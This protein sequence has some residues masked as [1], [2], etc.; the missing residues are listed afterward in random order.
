MAA[1]SAP[2]A[3]GLRGTSVRPARPDGSTIRS[4]ACANDGGRWVFETT[5]N[6]LP[7]EPTFAYDARRKKDRLTRANLHELLRSVGAEPLE[8]DMLNAAPQF[9]LLADRILD[10]AWRERVEAS[11][12]SLDEADDPAFGYLRRGLTCGPSY[13]DARRERD[14]RL[15]ARR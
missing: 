7:I 9:A 15:R 5:G 4:I 3:I 10:P 1:W 11:G 2:R 12:C 6:P 14:R 8:A 13:A